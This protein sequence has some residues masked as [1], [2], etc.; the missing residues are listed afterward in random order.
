MRNLAELEIDKPGK[1]PVTAGRAVRRPPPSLQDIA[2]FE[3]TFGVKL[4]AEYLEFLK[5]AN[6][7]HPFRGWFSP[8]GYGGYW[9][10]NLFYHLTSDRN[11]DLGLWSETKTWQHYATYPIIPIADDPC[12]DQIVLAYDTLVPNVK[13]IIEGSLMVDVAPSF[14]AFIDLLEFPVDE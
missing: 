9:D 8:S 2:D 6:G 12:G 5:F 7:G 11:E 13:L 1:R 14:E 4:P 3:S 10:V